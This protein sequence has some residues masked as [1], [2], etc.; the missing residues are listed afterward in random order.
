MKASSASVKAKAAPPLVDF[1]AVNSDDEAEGEKGCKMGK[2]DR[3]AA[4]A[5][6]LGSGDG[7]FPL[8]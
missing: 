8:L 5:K 7:V 6:K 4:S 3:Q 1:I 2:L